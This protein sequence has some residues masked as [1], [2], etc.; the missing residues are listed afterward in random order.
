LEEDGNYRCRIHLG[1]TNADK[2]EEDDQNSANKLSF[3]SPIT[4]VIECPSRRPQ[5]RREYF[6][7]CSGRGYALNLDSGD[8]GQVLAKLLD[9]DGA[10]APTQI[11]AGCVKFYRQGFQQRGRHARNW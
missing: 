2:R 10:G 4:F 8:T 3:T 5:G 6:A 1:L 9:F 11:V 7:S